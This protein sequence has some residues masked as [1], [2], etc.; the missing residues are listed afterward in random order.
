MNELICGDNIK[1]LK[2]MENN[3]I[4]LIVTSPP[5]DGLRNYNGYS[6]DFEGTAKQLYRVI[7][8]GGVVVWVVKDS[9]IK[10]NKSLT[11]F[12]QCI[13]FQEYGFNVFDVM[14]YSKTSGGMPHKNR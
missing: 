10:G 5:Y 8:E 3:C 11:S 1:I 6:F 2:T 14:I 4:D 12:K 13:K 9:T 7:K